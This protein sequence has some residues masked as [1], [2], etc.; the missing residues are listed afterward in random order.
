[1]SE[2]RGRMIRDMTLRG[3]SPRPHEAYIGAVVGLAKY[4]RRPPDQLTHDEVQASLAQLLQD[5]KLAWSSCSQAA[6]AFR[7]LY[8]VSLGHDRAQLQVPAPRLKEFRT[9]LIF[10]AVTGKIDVRGE[11]GHAMRIERNSSE[12]HG[13]V[14]E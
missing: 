14:W 6:H 8:H 10:A 3:L 12:F 11:R 5:R 13:I 1:M 2:L 9:A 4:Y 7:F